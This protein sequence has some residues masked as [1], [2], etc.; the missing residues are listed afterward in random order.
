M[1]KELTDDIIKENLISF[2]EKEIA[3]IEKDVKEHQF[4][5]AF[6]EQIDSIM[7]EFEKDQTN[8][9]VKLFNNKKLSSIAMIFIIVIT[10]TLSIYAVGKYL[11]EYSETK[12]DDHTEINIENFKELPEDYQFVFEEP[13][14]IPDGFK[15]DEKELTENLGYVIYV[16]DSGDDIIYDKSL[17]T[18]TCTIVLNTER[19][20]IKTIHILGKEV[21]YIYDNNEYLFY[22]FDDYEEHTLG[23]TIDDMDF[24]IKIIESIIKK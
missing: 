12:Y 24:H 23:S 18:G 16:N 3:S 6:N 10:S 1:R 8:R 2:S 9:S 22:W 13:S 21:F 14:Y 5:D 15:L 19:S 7:S 11:F 17:L 20:D 4:S